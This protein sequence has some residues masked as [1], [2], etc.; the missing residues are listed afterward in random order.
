[1]VTPPK[2]PVE[3]LEVT[4]APARKKPNI[5]VTAVSRPSSTKPKPHETPTED[6]REE[7]RLEARARA[8]SE[9][10]RAAND[11]KSGIGSAT[12]IDTTEGRGNGGA[13]YASYEAWVL[14]VFDNAWVAPEDATSEDATVKVSVTIASNGTVISKRIIQRSGDPAVDAS[15][16]RTLERV[17]TMGRPFP[18]GAKDK[19][20]SYI[21]PFNMKTKRGAA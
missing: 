18:E 1:V 13:S 2:T 3:S 6:T 8:A 7:A 14:T 10:G 15:V 12:R 21:I 4:K 11:I 20:R 5:T 19:Q 16:E 17:T 9:F